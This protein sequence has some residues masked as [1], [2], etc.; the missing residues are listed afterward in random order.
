MRTLTDKMTCNE[1]SSIPLHSREFS[2]KRRFPQI[3]KI[4]VGGMLYET[5][6]ATLNKY[7]NTLLG[8]KTK[9]NEYFCATKNEYFFNR[10]RESFGSIL[11]FYQS[12]GRLSRPENI[13]LGIF[14]SECEFFQIPDWAVESMKRREG[15]FI[16]DDIINLL[17]PNDIDRPKTLRTILWS[18]LEDPLSSPIAIRLAYFNVL[19]LFI[20]IL[21]NC[22][23][24]V[25]SLRPDKGEGH[26][27]DYWELIDITINSYFLL[28]FVLRLL[29]CPD[30][31]AFFKRFSVWIDFIALVTFPP[32]INKHYSK[33][34]I[35]LAFTPFQMFRV[36]RIFRLAKLFPGFNFA[37]IIM[38]NSLGGFINFLS[39]LFFL[40]AFG[41]TVLFSLEHEE[42]GT[43]FTSVPM[44]MYWAIQTYVT[45]GYGDMVPTTDLGKLF[46]TFFILCVIPTL[47]VPV[48][49]M[50][51]KFSKVFEYVG[52]IKE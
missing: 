35:L 29:S 8:N 15:G 13:N 7:P 19:L 17:N 52:A 27:H 16:E 11:F 41:G 4:N 40:A 18:F 1:T 6:I 48:L 23:K 30:L 49:A 44:A 45:V 47:S 12:A 25:K 2:T 26:T 39:F 36:I 22:L 28:E 38:K 14:L 34:G 20:S 31:R 43:T 24:T 10:H 51:L 46:A 5:C 42:I 3:V 9:R 50:F 32:M 33:D 37:V 21:I